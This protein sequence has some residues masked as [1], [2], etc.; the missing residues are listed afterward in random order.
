MLENNNLSSPIESYDSISKKQEE[1][2]GGIQ[3]VVGEEQFEPFELKFSMTN[4][5]Y[6]HGPPR[7]GFVFLDN[8][9]R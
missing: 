3:E 2:G 7:A 5:I 1:I 9:T 8:N 6:N 4:F